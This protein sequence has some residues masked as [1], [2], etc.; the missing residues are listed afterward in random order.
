VGR[1]LC[2][3]SHFDT[4]YLASDENKSLMQLF[5]EA[6]DKGNLEMSFRTNVKETSPR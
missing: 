2:V 4:R 5:V 6:F 1:S 3:P